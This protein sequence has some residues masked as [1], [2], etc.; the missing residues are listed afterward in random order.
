[1]ISKIIFMACRSFNRPLRLEGIYLS[2]N[3]APYRY[4]TRFAVTVF[5]S[6]VKRIG[7]RLTTEMLIDIMTQVNYGHQ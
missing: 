6:V 7:A 1:M 4:E 2:T 5:C 3:M